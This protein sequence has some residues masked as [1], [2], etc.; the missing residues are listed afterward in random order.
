MGNTIQA[1]SDLPECTARISRQRS[2]SNFSKQFFHFIFDRIDERSLTRVCRFLK[3][4][5]GLQEVC[6]APE[7]VFHFIGVR[8]CEL[9]GEEVFFPH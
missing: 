2:L 8:K 6:E 5:Q 9:F 3:G 1:Y 7:T 4:P